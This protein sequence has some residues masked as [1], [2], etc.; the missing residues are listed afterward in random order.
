MKNTS[1]TPASAC[2]VF[3]SLDNFRKASLQ[4]QISV[5][6][7]QVNAQSIRVVREG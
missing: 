5:A 3:V 4:I 1:L 6:D 7:K 2:P